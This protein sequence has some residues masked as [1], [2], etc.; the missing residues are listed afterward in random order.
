MPTARDNQK[1]RDL[2]R[3]LIVAELGRRGLEARPIGSNLEVLDREDHVIP[4]WFKAIKGESWQF[5]ID[6]FLDI[7]IHPDHQEVRGR[8]PLPDPSRV[9]IFVRILL[10]P[11]GTTGEFYVF[12]KREL[13]D[14]FARTYK[15]RAAPYDVGSTHC[16][17]WPRD[18]EKHRDRWEVLT[19]ALQA[20]DRRIQR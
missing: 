17:I 19:S 13:W 18:L 4:I 2:G 3:E 20:S 14:H 9:C 7:R 11:G 5:T 10:S 12:R 8:K 6:R 1:V 16:A 15:G